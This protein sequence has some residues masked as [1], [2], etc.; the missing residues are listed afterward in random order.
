[1]RLAPLSRDDQSDGGHIRQ[2]VAEQVY[3]QESLLEYLLFV[4]F[5]FNFGFDVRRR[6]TENLIKRNP[7]Y[8]FDGWTGII[9]LPLLYQTHRIVRRVL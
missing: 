7:I 6:D 3:A 8:R 2:H 9:L 1:M 5:C 4:F